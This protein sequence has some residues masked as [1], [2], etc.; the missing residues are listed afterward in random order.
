[1]LFGTTTNGVPL[2]S[3]ML[4]ALLTNDNPGGKEGID[5]G[6]RNGN[7]GATNR[8]CGM[9]SFLK[10]TNDRLLN[11][12]P[13]ESKKRPGLIVT[14]FDDTDNGFVS[15]NSSERVDATSVELKSFAIENLVFPLVSC[16]KYNEVGSSPDV[17][18]KVAP[19]ESRIVKLNFSYAKTCILFAPNGKLVVITYSWELKL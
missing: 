3:Y 8:I 10:K 12:T 16:E 11:V 19:E 5:M 18:D 6:G 4:D 17:F 13:L 1:L 9:V 14:L 15:V 7:V 2:M